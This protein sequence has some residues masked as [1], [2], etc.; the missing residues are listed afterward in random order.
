MATPAQDLKHY[1]L[2]RRIRAERASDNGFACRLS[3]ADRIAS[4]PNIHSVENAT[5]TLPGRVDVYLQAPSRSIRRQHDAHLLC[6]IGRDGVQVYGLREWDRHQVL[7]GGWGRLERDHV[8]IFLPRNS[9][10]L[11]VC[12]GMLQ[13]AY[14]YLSTVSAAAPLVRKTYPWDLPSFSRTTLQ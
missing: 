8:L 11:E 13:R 1:H 9:E 2:P 6:T 12:W 3:L 7:R 4:L 10:E 14:Q 5:D